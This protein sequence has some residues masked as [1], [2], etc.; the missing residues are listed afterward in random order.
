MGK[1]CSIEEVNYIR[2]INSPPFL[3]DLCG[4]PPSAHWAVFC[5]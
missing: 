4:K 2:D 3:R 5:L 1:I